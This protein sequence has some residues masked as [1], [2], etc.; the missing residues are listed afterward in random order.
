MNQTFNGIVGTV[1]FWPCKDGA[2]REHLRQVRA[3]SFHAGTRMYTLNFKDGVSFKVTPEHLDFIAQQSDNLKEDKMEIAVDYRVLPLRFVTFTRKDMADAEK[4]VGN[5]KTKSQYGSDFSSSRSVS[6]ES[7]VGDTTQPVPKTR[8]GRPPGSGHVIPGTPL[9]KGDDE[10]VINADANDDGD[11]LTT[12]KVKAL[13][14]EEARGKRQTTRVKSRN[15][16]ATARAKTP[17]RMGTLAEQQKQYAEQA[18]AEKAVAAAAK[19][20]LT[21]RAK[22][23][24]VKQKADA[25]AAAALEKD[26]ADAAAALQLKVDAQAAVAL[27]LKEKE[28]AE[29]AAALQLQEKVVGDAVAALQ[30]KENAE[31]AAT[32]EL[33]EKDEAYA[34]AALQLT[35]DAQA[36]LA[37]ALNEKEDAEAAA[38]LQLQEM[39]VAHAAA[40][41]KLKVDA[42]VA[43]TLELKEKDEADAAA[44]LQQKVDAQAAAALALKVKEDAEAAAALQLH[45]KVVADAA[46]ALK[47]K[48][49]KDE[50]DAAA[51]LQMQVDAQAAV[52]LALK[53]KED[54]EAA[55]ALQLQEKDKGAV[56]QKEDVDRHAACDTAHG[57]HAD[58]SV[59]GLPAGYSRISHPKANAAGRYPKGRQL[60]MLKRDNYMRLMGEKPLFSGHYLPK[61]K[62]MSEMP[63]PDFFID[64]DTT[65]YL[66]REVVLPDPQPNEHAE[67]HEQSSGDD[68]IDYNVEGESDHN[69]EKKRGVKKLKRNKHNST[70][71]M[72]QTLTTTVASLQQQM[73][74]L[75]T[76]KQE[77]VKVEQFDRKPASSAPRTSLQ[78]P[79]DLVSSS[80][81]K[82]GSTSE[83]DLNSEG[84]SVP[85]HCP[86]KRKLSSSTSSFDVELSASKRSKPDRAKQGKVSNYTK[87]QQL[88]NGSKRNWRGSMKRNSHLDK[89][90]AEVAECTVDTLPAALAMM[91]KTGW[92][93]IRNYDKI[94]LRVPIREDAEDYEE[95]VNAT[96]QVYGSV[97]SEGNAPSAAQAA[98]PTTGSFDGSFKKPPPAEP[99][100]EGVRVDTTSYQFSSNRAKQAVGES[101]VCTAS[102][103]VPRQVLKPNSPALK[104]YNEQYIGQMTDIIQGMFAEEFDGQG[105]NSAA[106]PDNWEFKQSV[107]WGGIE[108]QHQHC[109]QGQ[110]GSFHYEQIFPFVCIHGFGVH[111]FNMWLLPAKLKREYGFPYRF[112]PKSMLFM[113]GDM[114]HAG[115]VSQ[116]A[117]AHLE[118]F[119]KAAAGW[120]KT[121]Y[122]YWATTK[123][124]EEWVKKKN[125]FLVP[126][127]HT[128]PFAFPNIREEPNGSLIVSYPQDPEDE[129]LFPQLKKP[130]Q[131]STST[132]KAA[133]GGQHHTETSVLPKSNKRR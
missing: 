132:Y 116:P 44:A 62:A 40:A 26:D 65:A 85:D 56:K 49:A 3:K 115:G 12:T 80:D 20:E 28:D 24:A 43:A 71:Q 120:T 93:L 22:E 63:I 104:A 91:R 70:L 11:E 100:F 32:L 52:A 42:E 48:V 30:L 83:S 41:L 106:N 51:A 133:T 18:R 109:D 75:Q 59:A 90:K 17:A 23:A 128:F 98:Y 74:I 76:V 84:G 6:E 36:A 101:D 88:R 69:Q 117:R 34:A 89:I 95:D 57:K 45:E 55:A 105:R 50:A 46:A 2:Q 37:L 31:V 33:K 73:A 77:R 14:P 35:V 99:I 121:K 21:R 60:D 123:Q 19:A 72:F 87:R 13:V 92:A 114:V 78:H 122:P 96:V 16:A 129:D 10:E 25:E 7:D 102:G 5:Y 9:S 127:L 131:G 130:K 53:E 1:Y 86:K 54:A 125:T 103:N 108:H 67:D 29:A 82:G 64:D 81:E 126:D 61:N 15:N 39:V 8:R 47:L 111:E 4:E 68:N 118:F 113:R 66:L 112:P 119:P 94:V 79:L 107:V 124:F 110:A 38:A 58:V 97:F 27:A